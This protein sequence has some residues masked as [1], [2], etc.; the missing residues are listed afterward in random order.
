MCQLLAPASFLL[1]AGRST[2]LM[3]LY[4]ASARAQPA[5]TAWSS[6]TTSPVTGLVRLFSRSGLLTALVWLVP[7]P[8]AARCATI[9]P[10][11][12]SR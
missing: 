10:V 11:R 2:E 1:Q 5:S 4:L 12:V 8:S 7:L 6:C 3:L 9:A